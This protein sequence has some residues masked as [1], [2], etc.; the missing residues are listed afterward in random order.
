[1]KPTSVTGFASEFW[2]KRISRMCDAG[3]PACS[4]IAFLVKPTSATGFAS[5]LW[6]KRISA[7]VMRACRRAA[8]SRSC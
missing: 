2:Q 6:Q 8:G 1:V 5:Q 4:G 3:L 7:C